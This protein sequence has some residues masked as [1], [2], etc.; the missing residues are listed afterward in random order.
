M[1]VCPPLHGL[2]HDIDPALVAQPIDGHLPDAKLV[3]RPVGLLG[4]NDLGQFAALFRIAAQHE[5]DQ[6]QPEVPGLVVV[7]TIV[8]KIKKRDLPVLPAKVPQNRPPVADA[9]TVQLRQRRSGVRKGRNP[10]GN[11]PPLIAQDAIQCRTGIACHENSRAFADDLRHRDAPCRQRLHRRQ[12]SVKGGARG[13][14]LQPV[15]QAG[16]VD[17]LDP[18]GDAVQGEM[19]DPA[20]YSGNGGI[21]SRVCY[22]LPVQCHA[23]QIP[24]TLIGLKIR[25][26][27]DRGRAKEWPQ[28]DPAYR[29]PVARQTAGRSPPAPRWPRAAGPEPA[30]TAG[31]S[32]KDHG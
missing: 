10:F 14:L 5:S 1:R 8:L 9:G 3:L 7:G 19:S 23:V 26:R 28:A 24:R 22:D 25:P 11:G 4:R 30:N 29:P 21:E 18:I 27:P 17:P 6:V 12:V 16:L 32:P 2:G 20:R 31:G 15:D 13:A